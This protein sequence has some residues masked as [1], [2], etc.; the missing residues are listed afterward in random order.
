[1]RRLLWVVWSLSCLRLV[2]WGWVDDMVKDNSNLEFKDLVWGNGN[3]V[4][5]LMKALHVLLKGT[6]SFTHQWLYRHLLLKLR[7]EA[8]LSLCYLL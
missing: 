5:A 8:L 7:L 2:Q 3:G 4:G 1:M 6:R